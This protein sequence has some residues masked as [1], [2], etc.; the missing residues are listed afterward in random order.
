V[1][2]TSEAKLSIDGRRAVYRPSGELPP[3]EAARMVRDALRY[4]AKQGARE[5]LA[6]FSAVTLT[7][8]PCVVSRAEYIREWQE[9]A[10]KTVRLALV[11]R[12][13]AMD[14]GNFGNLF[15]RNIRF[16]AQIFTS[17]IEAS[18]WLKARAKSDSLSG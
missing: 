5:L 9:A 1:Q 4:S 17:L 16:D 18:V 7:R 13:E 11:V 10:Q 3:G 12:P 14:T 6:D 8:L 15:A 2:P